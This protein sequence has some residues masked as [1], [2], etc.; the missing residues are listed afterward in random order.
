MAGAA[1]WCVVMIQLG[2]RD[3]LNVCFASDSDRI[4]DIR[5]VPLWVKK[6][7]LLARHGMSVFPLEADV[8]LYLVNVG[9]GPE[10]DVAL[11][12]SPSA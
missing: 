7:T 11:P 6:A 2:E 8:P 1:A 4:A 10:P 5:G 9:F 12:F 3:L